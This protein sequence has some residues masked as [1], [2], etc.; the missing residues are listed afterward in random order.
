MDL[1]AHW[2]ALYS[3]SIPRTPAVQRSITHGSTSSLVAWSNLFR[4][5]LSLCNRREQG[6]LSTYDTYVLLI[7]YNTIQL[8]TYVRTRVR[9]QGHVCA[10]CER[11]PDHSRTPTTTPRGANDTER[12][13]LRRLSSCMLSPFHTLQCVWPRGHNAVGRRRWE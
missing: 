1:M 2:H 10:S 11:R 6:L 12:A 4:S 8:H 7:Q 9:V 13:P 5:N 3:P